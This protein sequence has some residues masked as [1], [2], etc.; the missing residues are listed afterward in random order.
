MKHFYVHGNLYSWVLT[1]LSLSVFG[2]FAETPKTAKIAFTS[3]R[4]GNA[5]IYLMNPDGSEQVNLT[6]SR[7]HEIGP[8]WAPTG[9]HILF[10]N[11]R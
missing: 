6:Q 7:H 5:E 10:T 4:D 2:I 11:A 9:K 3:T 1:L 8:A